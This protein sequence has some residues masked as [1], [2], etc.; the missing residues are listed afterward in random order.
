M[1]ART[2]SKRTNRNVVSEEGSAPQLRLALPPVSAGRRVATSLDPSAL[3]TAGRECRIVAVGKRRDGGTRYW[4]LEHRAD[5]TAKYGRRAPYCRYAHQAPLTRADV[6]KIDSRAY[7][8]GIALWGAVPPVY[9]TTHQPL[10]RGIHVHARAIAGGDKVIDQTYRAVLLRAYN[11]AGTPVEFSVSELDAIYYM[12]T[13]LFGYGIRY[14]ECTY[15]RHP[16]L[17]KDWFSVHPHRRHLCAGCGRNFRDTETAI[18]NPIAGLQGAIGHRTRIKPSKK[19]LKLR[20]RDFPGGIQI[21]GS[22][23]AIV[24]TSDKHE[25]AGIHVH[26][27]KEDGGCALPDDTFCEVVI[28]DITLDPLQVQTLMAQSALP[29]IAG[30]VKQIH[31][32]RCGE[33]KFATQESA[34]TPAVTHQCDSCSRQFPSTG[35]LRKVIANPMVGVIAQLQRHAV[36]A[37]Q[38]HSLDL[39]PETL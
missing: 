3:L 12:T 32:T 5:A 8:G 16:H 36:R 33:P 29:H 9:D 35:R 21:W 18:G 30:R 11:G 26:A 7:A 17:D 34:F 38:A 1:A 13:A 2:M 19:K 22:N 25:E 39:L 27:F 23:P 10:D 15:C 28:D 37:P 4:C 14:I 20:Q 24:W 31:C 6:L